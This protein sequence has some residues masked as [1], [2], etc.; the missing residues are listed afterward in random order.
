MIRPGLYRT[1]LIILSIILKSFNIFSQTGY[2]LISNYSSHDFRI[3]PQTWAITQDEKGVIFIGTNEGVL[4]FDGSTWRNY[5]IPLNSPVRSLE[6]GLDGKIYV[7]A[8]REFGFLQP[9]QNGLYQ[10]ISLSDSLE[11]KDFSAVLKTFV[12]D[13]RV[14][15]LASHQQIFE[16]ANQKVQKIDNTGFSNFRGFQIDNYVLLFSF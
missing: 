15:Y 9:D 1:L 4:R 6:Y 11:D 16:Y 12:I 10:Y 2:P 7:G 14:Y 8:S 13:D 3:N 5:R